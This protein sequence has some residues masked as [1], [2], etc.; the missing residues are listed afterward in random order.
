MVLYSYHRE[1]VEIFSSRT[2]T[3]HQK[4]LIIDKCKITCKKPTLSRLEKIIQL[5][6]S[7]HGGVVNEPFQTCGN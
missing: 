5:T 4:T 3:V 6:D 2:E 1:V 7:A